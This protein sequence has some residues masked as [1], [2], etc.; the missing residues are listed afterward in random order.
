MKSNLLFGAMWVMRRHNQSMSQDP[1]IQVH[2]PIMCLL[3]SAHSLLLTSCDYASHIER[4]Y[5]VRS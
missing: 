5:L 1:V 2:N 4:L 3:M